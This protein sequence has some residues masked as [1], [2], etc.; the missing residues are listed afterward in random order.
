M[1]IAIGDHNGR[2]SYYQPR[3]YQIE[4]SLLIYAAP[5]GV[6]NIKYQGIDDNGDIVV[7]EVYRVMVN[8]KFV[9]YYINRLGIKNYIIDLSYIRTLK[10]KGYDYSYKIEC[11]RKIFTFTH[12]GVPIVS[13]VPI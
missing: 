6:N 11:N 2:Y 12:N 8:G 4:I 3:R 5:I 10:S 13:W 7:A 9:Y 1:V